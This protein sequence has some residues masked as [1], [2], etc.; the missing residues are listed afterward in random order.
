MRTKYFLFIGMIISF[1]LSACGNTS[2]NNSSEVTHFAY[3]EAENGKWGIM[4]V[5]GEVVIQPT[6]QGMPTPVTDDMFFVPRQDGTYE[7]HNINEPEKIINANYTDVSSFS[8]G[9]AFV[10]R[11]GENISCI[12]KKGNILFA[13]SQDIK[14]AFVFLN[15][16]SLV[17]NEEEKWGYVDINGKI[18]IPCK[19]LFSTSF[20]NNHAVVVEDEENIYL[21]DDNGNK[22]TAVNADNKPETIFSIRDNLVAW[23]GDISNGVIPYVADGGFGLKNAEKNIVVPANPKYQL[24]TSSIYG[25]YIYRTENG[26]GVMDGTGKE[27][28]K[29]KYPVISNFNLNNNG[30]FTACIDDKWGILSINSEKQLCP[31]EY[32]YITAISN[33]SSYF[34]G[35]KNRMFY[36]I[37]KNGEIKKQFKQISTTIKVNVSQNIQ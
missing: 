1:F 7:L 12:D 2:A 26:Y 20:M 8:E 9:K 11:K 23:A 5:E 24:I 10:T 25:Y 15:K 17:I 36:L 6:F 19:Y 34:I 13:L 35:M 14:T 29:D 28:I 3:Q 37:T 32:D 4:S 18:I 27:I 16:R 33:N 22:I 31:F 30:I 21:I